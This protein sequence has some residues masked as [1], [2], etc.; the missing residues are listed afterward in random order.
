[1]ANYYSIIQYVPDPIANERMNIGVLVFS[2]RNVKVQFVSNWSRARN[3]RREDIA[4][5]RDFEKQVLML[6]GSQQEL[7][8]ITGRTKFDEKKIRQI[9]DTYERSIQFSKPKV[10]LEE[11]NTLLNY[12]TDRFLYH[13][14]FVPQNRPRT[15]AIKETK[16]ELEMAFMNEIDRT[17]KKYVQSKVQIAGVLESHEY[18]VGIVNGRPYLGA[19]GFSFEVQETKRVEKDLEALFYSFDDVRQESENIPLAF[20]VFPPGDNSSDLYERGQDV[21]RQL[22]VEM[23]P[24]N[25]FR[26]WSTTIARNLKNEFLISQ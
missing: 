24:E 8:E 19:Q 5:L 12:L 18:N 4:Y 16:R 2:G 15:T 7:E 20:V 17:A 14:E 9:I 10:S 21:C 25:R 11:A 6:T 26:K 22:K 1:M 23:V 13:P 3:F